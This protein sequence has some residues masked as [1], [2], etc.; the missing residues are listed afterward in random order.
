MVIL[1]AERNRSDGEKKKERMEPSELAAFQLIKLIMPGIKQHQPSH[2]LTAE[3]H[4]HNDPVWWVL[5]LLFCKR[6]S[7]L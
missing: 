2:T 7:N 1:G 6:K 4:C 5:L 3:S